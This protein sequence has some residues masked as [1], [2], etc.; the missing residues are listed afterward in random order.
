MHLDTRG[1]NVGAFC[2]LKAPGSRP[3]SVFQFPKSYVKYLLF[4][5]FN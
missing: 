4:V 3:T 1:P 5:V 2:H